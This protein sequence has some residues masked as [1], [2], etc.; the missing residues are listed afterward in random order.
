LVFFLRKERYRF[1]FHPRRQA[2]ATFSAQGLGLRQTDTACQKRK[3]K[4]KA[5]DYAGFG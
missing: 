5:R 3:H 4:N 1:Q 2:R